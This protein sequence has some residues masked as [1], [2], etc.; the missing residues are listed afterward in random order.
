MSLTGGAT[1]SDSYVVAHTSG[2]SYVW[3]VVASHQ[4]FGTVEKWNGI[5]LHSRLID[6]GLEEVYYVWIS[7]AAIIMFTAIFSGSNS[8]YGYILVPLFAGILWW[9]GWMPV[10][11][12]VWSSMLA[13]GVIAYFTRAQGV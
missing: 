2:A 9:I 11:F 13:V 10:S 7:I 1:A 4:D 5:T 3:G 6:L 8:K 12:L